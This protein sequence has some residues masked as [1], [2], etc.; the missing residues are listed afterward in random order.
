MKLDL[1]ELGYSMNDIK[2][3]TPIDA[4]QILQGK[5]KK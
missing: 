4:Q 5:T 1:L 2:A 3:M